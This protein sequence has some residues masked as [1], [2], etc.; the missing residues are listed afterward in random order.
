VLF[1][2]NGAPAAA[3]AAPAAGNGMVDLV[4]RNGAPAAAAPSQAPPPPPPGLCAAD[5]ALVE[6]KEPP[7]GAPVL[8]LFS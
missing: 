1:G 3:T 5:V 4:A 2:A 7:S 6:G 8:F